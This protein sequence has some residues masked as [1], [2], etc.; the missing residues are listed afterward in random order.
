MVFHIFYVKIIVEV[1]GLKSRRLADEFL[2]IFDV[3]SF[4]H[5]DFLL[6]A[7][8]IGTDWVA[9]RNATKATGKKNAFNI[10]KM[11]QNGM[12]PAN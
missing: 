12:V 11:D 3:F 7:D 10:N 6:T 9:T 1:D 5:R 2:G 8:G 4:A